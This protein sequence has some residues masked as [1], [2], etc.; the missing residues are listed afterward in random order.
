MMVRAARGPRSTPGRTG[1]GGGVAGERW[2]FRVYVTDRSPRSANA[3]A[4]L[5][6]L[7]EAHV[8]GRYAIEVVDLLQ[9]PERA[10]TDGIVA[11]PTIIRTAPDPKRTVIGDLA[12]LTKATTGLQLSA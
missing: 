3:L 7:C 11:I 4:N 5:T 1:R 12:D 2:A 6:A 9:T 8:P 10:R